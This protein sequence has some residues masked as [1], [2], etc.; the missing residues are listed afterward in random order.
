MTVIGISKDWA[1]LMDSMVPEILNLVI[2]TWEKM[3]SPASDQ[4]EDDITIALC[5]ALRQNRTVRNLM[6]QIDTQFVELDPLPGE[7]FGRLDIT[8]RPPIPREDIYFCLESK[9]LNVVKNGRP[10]SYASEYVKDGMFR[11]VKG[12]YSRAVRHGGMIAY[13][14]DGNVPR[15]MKNVEANIRK[16]RKALCMT[17]PGKFLASTVLKNDARAKETHHQ[18]AH[19]TGLFC[20]HHLFMAGSHPLNPARLSRSSGGSRGARRT[21]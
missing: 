20:I 6:F 21:A 4:R 12:Q 1:G 17:A 11:L 5:R 10:R 2:E 18:R 19:E 8:F 13:V 16:Q 7:H 3:P 15:A 9:R 14:L